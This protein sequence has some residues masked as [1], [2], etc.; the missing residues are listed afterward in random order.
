MPMT[1]EKPAENL[2]YD[3]LSDKAK[4]FIKHYLITKNGA[5][6]ARL[7][8]YSAKSSDSKASQLLAD[9]RIRKYIDERSD[10]TFEEWAE[11][12]KG[13]YLK[14]PDN[15]QASL[16]A[17]ELYGKGK[18][19]CR[20]A[21]VNINQLSVSGDDILRLRKSLQD[22]GLQLEHTTNSV[23]S[24]EAVLDIGGVGQKVEEPPATPLDRHTTPPQNAQQNKQSEDTI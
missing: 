13:V 21:T 8:G 17:L 9:V 16:K 23:A 6:S 7:A 5:K 3:R 22:K 20:D 18:G 2:E 14:H 11:K 19:F 10:W 12:V 24:N 1:E 15:W 4:S